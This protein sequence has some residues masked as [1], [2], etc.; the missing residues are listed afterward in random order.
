MNYPWPLVPLREVLNE[1]REVPEASDLVSGKIRIVA[2]IGF[3]EG[4]IELR[5]DGETRTNMILIRPGDL[6]LS[7]INAGKGAIAIYDKENLGPV[8][9]TIHYGAYIVNEGKADI[10]YLWWLLRS[11]LFREILLEH[12]PGGIK[13]ELKA[14][15]LL[16]IPIPLPEISEQKRIVT[17][18]EELFA[19]L[20]QAHI[21]RKYAD[22]LTKIWMDSCIQDTM[23]KFPNIGRFEEVITFRP[24]SGPSFPTQKD[25]KG[26]PVLMP[27]S[28]TGFGVDISKT[29]RGIGNE[30][31]NNKDLL[32]PG[33][34]II[35]R[36][37]K[38]EQ[39]GNAGV[40]PIEAKSWVCANLLMR[41]QVDQQKVIPSFCIYW[42]RSPNMR[43]LVKQKMTGT[44]PNIQK[45]NQKTILDFPFPVGVELDTQR[46]IV[47]YLDGLQAQVN[48]L[49]KLQAQTAAE[50]DALLPAILDRAFKGEL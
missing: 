35:A 17:K 42:L 25:W 47:A 18:V 40:V 19:K 2:K 37:N 49:K 23:N 4:K 50:L 44:S 28:V 5:S 7:G 13:T 15:R 31:I 38:V 10:R 11:H 16:S 26:T 30:S 21:Y 20:G 1:R 32:M 36:G 14:K 12:L 39:V 29:E 27:S 24:R 46:R 43:T 22:D 6:V 33:D 34:I 41:L 9:A 3:N 45:I 8:A 48:A